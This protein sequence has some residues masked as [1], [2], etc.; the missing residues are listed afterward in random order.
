MTKYFLPY[1]VPVPIRKTAF[2]WQ[3]GQGQGASYSPLSV[4][5]RL[6]IVLLF[7]SNIYMLMGA[8]QV[9]LFDDVAHMV[10]TR[11]SASRTFSMKGWQVTK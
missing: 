11:L 9:S 10:E 6:R 4:P 1:A 2:T 8:I 3:K 7:G 5:H